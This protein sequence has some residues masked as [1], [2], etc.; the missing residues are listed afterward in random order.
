[1]H[2]RAV[3]ENIPSSFKALML[4]S[5]YACILDGINWI[6]MNETSYKKYVSLGGTPVQTEDAV[7]YALKI[8]REACGIEPEDFL[9]WAWIS[10]MEK[11][12][13]F[14]SYSEVCQFEAVVKERPAHPISAAYAVWSRVAAA[15]GRKFSNSNAV[16]QIA[17]NAIPSGLLAPDAAESLKQKMAESFRLSEMT[18]WLEKNP[19]LNLLERRYSCRDEAGAIA[20]V[21]KRYIV[22]E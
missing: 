14:K 5:G 22:W 20:D 4:I 3:S 12:L 8:V 13:H 11:T 18:E 17:L 19:I 10:S 21:V 2:S 1:M 6:V 7:K 16:A 9:A 15:V